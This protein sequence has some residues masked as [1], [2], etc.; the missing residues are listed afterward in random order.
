[1]QH[2]PDVLFLSLDMLNR[3]LGNP[4]WSRTFGIGV[5][6]PPHLLLLDEVHAYEGIHG[7]QI[8]WV[9]RRWKHWA[10]LSLAGM[11]C[12]EAA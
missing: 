3:E 12:G 4:A 10:R 7:A 5:D 2:P 6:Q 11:N 9:V 1:M 8:S